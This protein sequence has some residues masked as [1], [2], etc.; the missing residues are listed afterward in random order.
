[1]ESPLD[2]IVFA[3]LVQQIWWVAVWGIAYLGV[4]YIAQGS[5]GLELKIYIVLLVIVGIILLCYPK[6]YKHF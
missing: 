2:N 3:T 5:K 6:L 1:M 4:E